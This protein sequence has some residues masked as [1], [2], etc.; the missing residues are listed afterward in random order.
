MS[1][2]IIT[3]KNFSELGSIV[4]VAAN[5]TGVTIQNPPKAEDFF[6]ASD[7]ASLAQA[8]VPA[9]TLAIAFMFPD[10]HRPGDEWEKIDYANMAKITRAATAGT[11]ALANRTAPVRWLTVNPKA[12]RYLQNAP[13]LSKPRAGSV[14]GSGNSPANPKPPQSAP[15]LQ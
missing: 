4:E 2:A 8:G 5:R 7:N 1:A 15:S 10:Y 13:L 14:P 11:L 9:H 12:E 6:V 3:G